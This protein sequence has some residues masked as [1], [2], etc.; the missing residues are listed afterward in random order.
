[1]VRERKPPSSSDSS[2][3][4]RRGD[5]TPSDCTRLRIAQSCVR[6]VSKIETGKNIDQF[7]KSEAYTKRINIASLSDYRI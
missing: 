2:P 5:R 6:M 1:M 7:L 3:Q 4:A